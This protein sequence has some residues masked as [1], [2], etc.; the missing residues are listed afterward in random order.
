MFLEF[1]YNVQA[2]FHCIV[3]QNDTNLLYKRHYSVFRFSNNI[4]IWQKGVFRGYAQK[5]LTCGQALAR[6]LLFDGKLPKFEFLILLRMFRSSPF[7]G[8]SISCGFDFY[9]PSRPHLIICYNTLNGCII[10]KTRPNEADAML[11]ITRI[12]R[13]CP[14]AP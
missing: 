14:P 3:Y 7:Y 9:S 5:H 11:S 4:Y 1:L 10:I 12:K 13:V 8:T 2:F 6:I